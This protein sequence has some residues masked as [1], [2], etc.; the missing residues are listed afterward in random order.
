VSGRGVTERVGTWRVW[1]RDPE[2]IALADWVATVERLAVSADSLHR[3]K[4]ADTYRWSRPGG[5]VYVKIYRRY[6]RWTALKDWF[7]PSKAANVLRVS[8][9]LAGKGFTVP[10]VVA[11]GEE[12]RALGVVRSFCATAALVGEPIAERVAALAMDHGA[13]T[14]R[15]KRG[16]L[17]TLGRE[18]A[19]LHRAGIVAGD[20]VPANV[21][22]A[23]AAAELS[24]AF[25]DHDRTRVGPAPAPWQRARRNLVQL[26]RVVLDGVGATDRLRVYRAYARAQAW[27]KGDARR[28]LPWIIAKTVERRR[29]ERGAAIPAHA[30]FRTVMRAGGP[31]AGGR[32]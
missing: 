32:A 16:L 3:S 9:A 25:L 20:L 14:L 29:A 30:D 17:D 7:R 26:N 6:R 28:R 22:I 2:T 27:T 5:D 21:W 18:V 10:E 23:L 11:I 24:I 1:A 19:R 15:A 31:H 13:P 4:H 12:R 8:A